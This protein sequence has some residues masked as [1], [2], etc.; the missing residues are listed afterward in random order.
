[1]R[2]FL[3]FLGIEEV[4]FV[5]AE[6]LAISDASRLESL[7]RAQRAIRRLVAPDAVAVAA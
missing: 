3:R 4:E 1:M 2:D 6:G 7:A 5:Y